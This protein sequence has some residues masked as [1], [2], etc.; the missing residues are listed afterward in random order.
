MAD[1]LDV[2]PP[3]R[4][5]KYVSLSYLCPEDVLDDKNVFVFGEFLKDFSTQLCTLFDRLSEKYPTDKDMIRTIKMN[6]SDIF[7]PVELQDRYRFFYKTHYD[8]LEQSFLEKNE[9]KTCVRGIKIRGVY[10]TKKEADLHIQKLKTHDTK[11]NIW[12]GDLGAWLPF[13]DNPEVMDNQTYPEEALNNLM[14]EYVNNR[15]KKDAMFNERKQ[16]LTGKVVF[17]SHVESG[18]GVPD[19]GDVAG[20]SDSSTQ[21]SVMSGDDLW[22]K[23]KTENV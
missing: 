9:F 5:Q 22:L 11:H 7:D 21:F 17:D 13:V 16:E 10:P 6:N 4:G 1:Y 14:K 18:D 20:P 2:D 23:R 15:E 8:S 12:L 3:I 19:A